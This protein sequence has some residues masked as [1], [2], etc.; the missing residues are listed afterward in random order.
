MD[1]ATVLLLLCSCLETR[2]WSHMSILMTGSFL[3]G[4]T[5]ADIQRQRK[6]VFMM[7]IQ[8]QKYDRR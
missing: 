8:A 2:V 7:D 5:A 4:H 3:K 6:H 1:G